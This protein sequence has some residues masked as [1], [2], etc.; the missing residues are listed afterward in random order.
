MTRTDRETLLVTLIAANVL[1][2]AFWAWQI[3]GLAR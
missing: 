2:M 3:S 1:V